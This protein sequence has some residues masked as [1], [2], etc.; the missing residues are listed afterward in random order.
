MIFLSPA[1]TFGRAFLVLLSSGPA[2]AFAGQFDAMGVVNEAVKNRVGVGGIADDLVPAV[3]GEL[4]CDHRRAAAVSLLE[5]FEEIVSAGGVERLE[6]PVVLCGRPL[7]ART[8]LALRT[9]WTAAIVCPAFCRG[10]MTPR[11]R[12]GVPAIRDDRGR[13]HPRKPLSR[14]RP[15][16]CRKGPGRA[17]GRASDD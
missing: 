17:A 4:G 13:P 14:R 11:G 8:I 10:A 15:W 16:P 5:D 3:Y 12:A 9:I 1:L 6:A 2:H 7:M